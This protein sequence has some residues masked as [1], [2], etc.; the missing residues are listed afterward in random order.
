MQ[1]T[2]AKVQGGGIIAGFYG[3][4]LL[5]G[6]SLGIHCSAL[7]RTFSGCCH[8]VSP[9]ISMPSISSNIVDWNTSW[10][11][12]REAGEHVPPEYWV[13][14][15]SQV[16]RELAFCTV[17]GIHFLHYLAQTQRN[18]SHPGRVPIPCA[19]AIILAGVAYC[20]TIQLLIL[21]ACARVMVVALCFCLSVRLSITMLA[22]LYLVY[23]L[24]AR[25]H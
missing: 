5:A 11:T 22:A 6:S 17:H 23:R 9:H 21:G 15:H 20:L 7:N 1:G 16:L 18:K 2:W 8:A 24:K 19:C 10:D 12:K 14:S 25:C 13:H 4:F 3:N